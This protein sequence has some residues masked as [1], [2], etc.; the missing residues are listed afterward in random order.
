MF[1]QVWRFVT[2]LL[3]ALAL[4][5]T[6]AHVLELPQ[7]MHYGAELYSAVNTTMYRYFAIVGG[8]YLVGAIV[9]AGVLAYLVRDHGGAFQWAFAGAL[10]QLLAFVS[11][12]V[13]VAP[14]N[15]RIEAALEGAPA[16]VPNL[17]LELRP[18]WEYGHAT[19]FVIQLLGFSALLISVLLGT[20]RR[21]RPVGTRGPAGQAAQESS[22]VTPG[23]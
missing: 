19:G 5:M 7:K 4:S 18:R 15:G 2:I 8:L 9:S 3:A 11:W 13:L 23:P 10:T 14:V 17:W 1:L 20:P 16:T 22:P 6:S 21:S 12:L